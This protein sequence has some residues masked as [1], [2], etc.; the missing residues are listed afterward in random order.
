MFTLVAYAQSARNMFRMGWGTGLFSWVLFELLT[1]SALYTISEKNQGGAVDTQTEPTAVAPAAAV[2][3]TAGQAAAA[4]LPAA[5][6]PPAR[7]PG[8]VLLPGVPAQLP[9]AVLPP[10]A[11][12]PAVAPPAAAAPPAVASPAAATLPQPAA[13]A[14]APA[15]LPAAVAPGMGLVHGPP[16]APSPSHGFLGLFAEVDDEVSVEAVMP[17]VG[18]NHDA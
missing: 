14:G 5:V 6:L 15:A 9:A 1:I 16:E 7:L 18:A 17:P 3:P 8:A 13:A 10:A 12:P 4:R 2:V 11:A